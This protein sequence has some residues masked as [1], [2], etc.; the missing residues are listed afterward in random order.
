MARP[1]RLEF[2]GAVYHVTSRGNARRAI[3]LDDGDRE[4]FLSVLWGIVERFHWLCH[5]YCLMDN[6]YHLMIETPEGNLSK[7]MRQLNGVYTQQF[8]RRH[9]RVGHVFQGRYKAI[10]VERD[11]YLLELSR[12]IVLNPVRAGMVRSAAH[13]RWSSYRATG[14]LGKAPA[15]L[16]LRWVLG[17]FGGRKAEAKRRYREFVSAGLGGKS[18]WSEVI[19]QLFLGSK[20]FV[21]D[22]VPL[23]EGA[24]L[25]TEVPREQRFA[26]RPALETIFGDPGS[27]ELGKRNQMIRKAV[28][29]YGYTLTRIG[30]YLGLHYSHISRI[31]KQPQDKT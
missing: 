27:L 25:L 8:N 7:G 22:H 10:V 23:L 4:V 26:D 13:Y 5:A 9:R 21:S 11:S 3:F 18:P 2:P 20:E 1:L 12:Y 19:G 28:Y 15:G 16:E 14:G 30:Q 24:A 31:A 29:D 6:H 17:Q